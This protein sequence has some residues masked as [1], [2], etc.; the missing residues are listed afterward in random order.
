MYATQGDMIARFGEEQLV[1]LTDRAHPPTDVIDKAVLEA[2]LID[3]AEVVDS[4]VAGR[5]QVPLSPV[6]APVRRWCA[7][8][9]VYYL[10]RK[11]V[12]EHIRKAY[13]DALAALKDVAKGTI[14]L[15]AA[16][17]EGSAPVVQGGGGI[18]QAGP[19]RVFS[20]A[21]LKGF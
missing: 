13:E 19:R 12:P 7:D 18:Q 3:A 15:Q 5:Y 2:A 17:V 14:Q 9:S 21:S 1:Q 16:G 8:M 6:P 4:Y 11:G 10:H 20:A